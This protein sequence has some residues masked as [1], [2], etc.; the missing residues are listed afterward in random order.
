[1][2]GCLCV[3]VVLLGVVCLIVAV[4]VCRLCGVVCLLLVFDFL[5]ACNCLYLLWC[6][7]LFVCALSVLV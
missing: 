2:F 5:C 6:C 1:M 7:L 3:L 4:L